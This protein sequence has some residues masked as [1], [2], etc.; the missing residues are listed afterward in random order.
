LR[1]RASRASRRTA[2]RPLWRCVPAIWVSSIGA[3]EARHSSTETMCKNV[4]N[5]IYRHVNRIPSPRC[6]YDP[7]KA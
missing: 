4:D 2:R 1:R 5:C 6:R 3:R 7:G